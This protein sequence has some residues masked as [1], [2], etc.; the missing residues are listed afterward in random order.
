[1]RSES[2]A[3]QNMVFENVGNNVLIVVLKCVVE[4]GVGNFVEGS[5][6]GSK[7]LEDISA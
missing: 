6:V 3:L 4:R 1:M 7:D 5:I 2:S